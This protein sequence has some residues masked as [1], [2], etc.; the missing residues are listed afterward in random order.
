MSSSGIQSNEVGNLLVF[1]QHKCNSTNT[2]ISAKDLAITDPQTRT[3]H[4][5]LQPQDKIIWDKAYA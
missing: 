5:N 4:K 1:K 2:H 3:Q